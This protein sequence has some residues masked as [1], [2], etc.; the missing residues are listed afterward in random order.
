MTRLLLAA[1]LLAGC[2]AQVDPSVE[3]PE[4]GPLP[5]VENLSDCSEDYRVCAGT[6]STLN[7]YFYADGVENHLC[8]MHTGPA[9]ICRV[10]SQQQ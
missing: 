5:V 7:Y 10:R 2:A 6:N 4:P 8:A 3:L 9:W 1:L